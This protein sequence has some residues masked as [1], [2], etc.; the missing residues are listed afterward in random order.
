MT[1]SNDTSYNINFFR[2]IK[3]IARDSN[4]TITLFLIIWFV[5]VFGFQ[6]LL[7]ATNKLTPEQTLITFREV[8][9]KA[10]SGEATTSE[11][12]ELS[13][14]L[15]MVLGKNIALTE[16]DKAVL[17]EALSMTVVKLTPGQSLD[18]QVL[19]KTLNLETNKFGRIMTELLPYS[20][21]QPQSATYNS[22]LPD[23]MEKYCMHPQGPLTNLKFLGFPFHYW[24]TAQFLLI[25]FVLLCLVFAFRIEKLYRKNNYVEE[26]D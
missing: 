2:P 11:L 23:I 3:G 9:P 13:L 1:D 5:A 19:A 25:L 24:Y 6:F 21:V 14:S 7:I 10:K 16:T 20:L 18:P 12:Q 15:I 4:R 22:A 26:H 8:W 17:K